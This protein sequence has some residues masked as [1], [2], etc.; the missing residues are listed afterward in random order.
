MHHSK[1]NFKGKTLFPNPSP[2]ATA[3]NHMPLSL[4]PDAQHAYLEYH[5]T[6]SLKQNAIRKQ[7]LTGKGGLVTLSLKGRG[8]GTNTYKFKE[9]DSSSTDKH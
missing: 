1:K 4:N 5:T 7:I 8:G 2:T 3:K 9:E 6:P